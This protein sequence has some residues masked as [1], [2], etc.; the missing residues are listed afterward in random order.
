LDEVEPDTDGAKQSTMTH[1]Q[2]K[3]VYD[4]IGGTL[5]RW[6]YYW[7]VYDPYSES[8]HEAVCGSVADDLSDIYRDL[9]DGLRAADDE[10]A[11]PNDVFWAWRFDFESH[12]AAHAAGA[13]RALSTA[14][15]VHHAGELPESFGT[16]ANSDPLAS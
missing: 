15:F 11:Q 13:L 2:W 3:I 14:F 1:D 5:G 12:W 4:D 16:K 7:D 10:T 8:D 6:N 9:R